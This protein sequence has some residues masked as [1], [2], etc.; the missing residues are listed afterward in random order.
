MN[1]IKEI[2][3][4]ML[5]GIANIIPGV[6]G[7]TMAVSMGVYDKLILAITGIRKQFKKSVLTLLPILIGALAGIGILSFVVKRALENYPMQTSGLF[8]GLIIGGIPM[9]VKRAELKKIGIVH[10]I[11]FLAFFAL[12]IGMAFMSGNETA[13]TDI[14]VNF[15]NIIKLFLV[16]IIASA[17]MIIPGV[18]GSLVLMILGFYSIIISNISNFLEALLSFDM[19]AIWHGFGIFVPLGLGILIGIGLIAKLIEVLF[20]KAPKLTYS[21]ILGLIIGSPIAILYEMGINTVTVGSTIVT[22]IAFSIGFIVSYY[23]GEG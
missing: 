11:L 22:V 1:I 6:S 16:G 10:I 20:A 21:A 13:A 7:G 14:T 23:L 3:K 4:G 15:G 18:S 2:L 17:T 19:P 5:I 9:I 12:V 8:I